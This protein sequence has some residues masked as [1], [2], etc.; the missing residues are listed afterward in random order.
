METHILLA[1][2]PTNSAT[3]SFISPAALFVNVIAKTSY[4]ATFRFASKYAIRLVKTRVFPEPAPATTSK[5]DPAWATA[6]DCCGFNP[7]VKAS[8]SADISAILSA[9]L[10]EECVR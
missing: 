6:S 4:G 7:S 5:G 8:V 10:T 3:R 1:R 9:V 2:S